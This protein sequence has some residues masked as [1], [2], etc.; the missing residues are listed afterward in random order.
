VPSRRRSQ[1]R[2]L[3][4]RV[5]STRHLQHAET[6]SGTQRHSPAR[7]WRRLACSPE[8]LITTAENSTDR[9]L[10]KLY[11]CY[12]FLNRRVP[13]FSPSFARSGPLR[14]SQSFDPQFPKYMSFNNHR[15]LKDDEPCGMTGKSHFSQRT[16]EK[17]GT[18]EIDDFPSLFTTCHFERSGS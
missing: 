10:G 17:W 16:P 8:S 12:L 11:Y 7:E 13:H 2:H 15:S 18:P 1:P 14:S 5:S 4:R 3:I 9:G 6:S